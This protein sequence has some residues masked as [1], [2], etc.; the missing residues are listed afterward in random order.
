[1]ALPRVV[2]V[3]RPNVGKSTLFN[4]ISGTRIAI[5]DSVSGSTRDRNFTTAEWAGKRFELVDTGGLFE[6]PPSEMDRLVAAQC[7]EAI[8]GAAV[9]CW[10]VDGKTGVLPE[11][12]ALAARL[13]VLA[14]K[15]ILVV[16]KIDEAGRFADAFE[17]HKLG[18]PRVFETSADHGLGVAELLDEVV[19]RLPVSEDADNPDETKLAIVG[20]PNVGKSSLLNALIGEDRVI[21]SPVAGT[22]RDAVDTILVAH[23]RTYRIVD[24]A[25][26][27][28][29]GKMTSR[30]DGLAVLYAERAI[31]RAHVCLLVTDATEGFTRE[32]ASI[33]GKIKDA[34]RAAI[35]V[36]N[37]WDLIERREDEAKRMI[38]EAARKLRHLDFAPLAFTS[39]L[40]GKGLARLLP[41]VDG[42]RKEHLTRISTPE[43]NRFVALLTRSRPPRARG[44]K[45]V[46]V[47]Y[48][49]QA[50]VGPPRFVF[51]TNLTREVDPAYVRY[52]GRALRE[53][54]GFEGT[55]IKVTLKKKS[56][57]GKE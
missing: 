18:F 12:I 29:R 4:R 37:K 1:L 19:E 53:E 57:R 47:Y 42:V 55:P 5:V 16:N 39:A 15:V 45:E 49:V 8:S 13:R 23:G 56:P 41:L 3:G 6:T 31:E 2:V 38:R 22:T 48:A 20:R 44:G 28:R 32:D 52:L 46:K 54:Y 30:A 14:D 24:T 40:R 25:G 36:L 27:R 17:F 11:D 50:G 51:F 33:A 7:E 21:V 34:G 9:I 26:V 35:V 43:L 10:V